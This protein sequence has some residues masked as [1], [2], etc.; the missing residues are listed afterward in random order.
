M[1]GKCSYYQFG[2]ASC[3]GQQIRLT[4]ENRYGPAQKLLSSQRDQAG[5]QVSHHYGYDAEQR[6]TEI[7]S[8][9]GS[10][11]GDHLERYTLDPIANRLTHSEQPGP[12]TYDAN[13]RLQQRGEG[14][15]ATTYH[16]DHAGNLI[17]QTQGSGDT[18]RM[19]HYRY[20]SDHR[21]NEIQTADQQPIARYGYDPQ[22]RRLWK[23]QY[24]DRDGQLLAQATRTYYLYSD[25]SLLA[26]AT[27]PITLH[28]DGS[29][30]AQGEPTLTAQYGPHPQQPFTTGTLFIKTRNS[31]G[32][33]TVGYYQ[34]DHLGT[35]IQAVDKT[36]RIVWAADYHAFGQATLIT[37]KAT[38]EAPTISS[39]LRL[40]GQYWDGE[41]GLHYNWH[42]YYDPE[43]GRY[44]TRDPIGLEGG[45]NA[46][47]YVY[48][49]PLEYG[50]PTG[51]SIWERIQKIKDWLD[52]KEDLYDGISCAQW[53]SKIQK[54]QI[55][56]HKECPEGS[57]EKEI[58]FMDKYGASGWSQA[59]YLCVESKVGSGAMRSL[60]ERCKEIPYM[61]PGRK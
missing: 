17:Q 33:D 21:L 13:Q 37:P 53:I 42:R 27:Q 59:I 45:V 50:D 7:R 34:H 20:D 9:R 11:F 54:A 58:A 18:A 56:C 22:H 39:N 36:G 5:Q 6:L 23:E 49:N 47:L 14:S 35:P 61:F 16:Y 3:P 25:H 48:A 24:R 28:P 32:Q 41:S 40:P 52:R 4:L 31:N 2:T 19:T 51:K 26:E 55:E 43:V 38:A 30:S 44:I 8:D 1:K 57:I 12:W 60:M 46:Y 29:V 15:S 10:L